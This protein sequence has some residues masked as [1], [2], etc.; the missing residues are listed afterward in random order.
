[1]GE[2]VVVHGRPDSSAKAAFQRLATL[3]VEEVAPPRD[4]GGCTARLFATVEAA[5]EDLDAAGN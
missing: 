3:V 2:P 5:F 4:L 1:T